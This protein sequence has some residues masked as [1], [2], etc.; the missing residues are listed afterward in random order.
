MEQVIVII[1]RAGK[2]NYSAYTDYD[3]GRF[4]VTG[5][6]SSIDE[7]K[8]DFLSA[9]QEMKDEFGSDDYDFVFY[10]D[11]SCFLQQ[12]GKIISF[13]GIQR[14]TGINQ[15]QLSRY[16]TGISKPSETTVSKLKEGIERLRMEL[17][18]YPMA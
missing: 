13:A 18:M 2:R 3:F 14:L 5:Y 17:D 12:F 6:G 4:G 7:A 8:Q 1:E 11:A 16:A 10:L 15:K 9:F